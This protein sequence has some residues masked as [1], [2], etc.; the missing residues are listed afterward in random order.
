MFKFCPLD[1]LE[2]LQLKVLK[3]FYGSS[4]FIRLIFHV[5]IMKTVI[6]NLLKVANADASN[7][8]LLKLNITINNLYL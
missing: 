3:I 4:G 1:F 2:Q 7:S 6:I 8:E 5:G